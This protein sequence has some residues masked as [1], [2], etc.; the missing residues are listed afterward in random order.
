MYNVYFI[1]R[2][3][4]MLKKGISADINR[5]SIL[6]RLVSIL[7]SSL[8]I[9]PALNFVIL[10]LVDLFLKFIEYLSIT[11]RIYFNSLYWLFIDNLSIVFR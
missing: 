5:L 11:Y 1:S 9:L 8:Q 7:K 4:M 2:M 3:N 6:F 10:N